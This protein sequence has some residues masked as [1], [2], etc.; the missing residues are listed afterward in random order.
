VNADRLAALTG[1][2]LVKIATEDASSFKP[3]GAEL[4]RRAP[5]PRAADALIDAYRK[6]AIPPWLVAH[7]LGCVRA[8]QGYEVAREVLLAAPGLLAESYAGPAMARIAGAAAHDDLVGIMMNAPRLRSREGAAYGL[9]VLKRPGTASL[10]LHAVQAGRVRRHPAAFIVGSLPDALP[11][12]LEWFSS[13]DETTEAM[14]LDAAFSLVTQT[15]GD[16]DIGLAWAIRR[17]L[18]GGR[19][20]QAPRT[21]QAMLMRIAPVL[22]RGT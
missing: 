20:K 19:V 22:R 16:P 2:Q 12:I 13:E 15:A 14:A 3:V 1:A 8:A 5:D 7:L 11:A 18:D 17:T 21:R 4:E 9:S 10:V 6:G